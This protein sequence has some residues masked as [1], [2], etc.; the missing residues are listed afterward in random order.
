MKKLIVLA[1]VV[2]TAALSQAASVTWG[3][4]GLLGSD[5]N[6]LNSGA[7]Y[8]FCTKGTSG[9][10]VATVTAALAALTSENDLKTYL[11]SNSL[12]A[13]KSAVASG[14]AG[15]SSV[16]LST[17][18]VP[19]K[20]TGTQLFAVIVD[21]DTFATGTKYVVTGVSGNVKTPAASTTNVATFSIPNT[22]TLTAS[23]W[24]AV[25]PEPTSG[26]L[27]LVGLGALAL[28]RRRA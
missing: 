15:V 24:T 19:E 9:T 7:A 14:S 1:A 21:D 3:V 13:L 27:M 22:A 11:Q 8:V 17:S 12:G 20:T 23:N 6:T 10:S 2:M 26:L 16:D 25:A 4:N 18:G 28:R 5:G